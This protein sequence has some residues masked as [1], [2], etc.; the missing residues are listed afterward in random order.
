MPYHPE[1]RL[2]FSEPDDQKLAE[3]LRR[4]AIALSPFEA[5]RLVTL[6]GREPTLA[7]ATLFAI[8]WSEHCSYKSSRALLKKYLP[9]EGPT[10][11]QGPAEDA[12]IL[13]FGVWEGI[14]YGLVIAHESHNHPSQVMPYEGAATGI[15]GIVR[16]V[17]CMGGD[18]LAVL[19]PLR[20]G[21]PNG[22]NAN[23]TREIISGVVAGIAGYGN[24]LGVPNLGGDVVFADCYDDNC[25]VN[26]GAIGIVRADRI[27]PS[28]VPPEAKDVQYV[29]VL[30]GKATDAS[31]FGG[32]AFASGVLDEEDE[33]TNKGAVQIPDPFLKRLLTVSILT[34][35][36]RCFAK[37]IK[38][39]FKD[40]GAGG[41][42]CASSEMAASGGF[43]V[44]VDLGAVPTSVAGL[45]PQ[46]IAC[47]ETQERYLFYVPEAFAQEFCVIFN[48][49][50]RIPAITPGAG[51]TVVGR[52]LTEQT[53]RAK[54]DDTTYIECPVKAITEGIRYD[55]EAKPRPQPAP[56]PDFPQP[57]DLG[58]V[59]AK[60]LALP[61][62]SS[63]E[64]LFRHYDTEVK[65]R[66]VI[67]PGEA[68]AG[69]FLPVPGCPRAVALS[70]DGNPFYGRIDPYTGGA[71]A[72]EECCRNL[73][74]V[75]ALPIGITDCLN[76]GNPEDPESFWELSEGVRGIGEACNGIG[77]LSDPTHPLPV[78]SG[79]VSLYNFSATGAS[80][81]PSPIIVGV[82]II[83]DVRYAITSQLKRAGGHLFLVGERRKELGGSEYLRMMTGE[84]GSSVPRFN[85]TEARCN[86]TGVMLAIQQG[87]VHACHDISN[88][89]LAVTL[90]EM[91]LSLEGEDGLGAILHLDQIDS[92]LRDDYLLFGETGGFICEVTP[93]NVDPFQ[94]MLEFN[95][96]KFWLIGEVV[97]KPILRIFKHDKILVDKAISDLAKGW[98]EALEEIMR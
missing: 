13:D 83:P 23:R 76:Y 82:G 25:L 81:Y 84:L 62:L 8:M 71:T 46:V 47:A 66:T 6:L 74:A 72:V 48:Q 94:S 12:G 68:D 78:V 45:Q 57:A 55:R 2:P 30:V 36:D 49:E 91:C 90:A 44:E 51:A 85:A 28:K 73:V 3:L 92:D 11:I 86:L 43:G 95:G 56:D 77:L 37:G 18:V 61:N 14:R 33:Q 70:C 98:R 59:L 52:T 41:F 53:Y 9:T 64:Y 63:R 5:R 40:L 54:K 42:A 31:G 24:P 60:M 75:G 38:I 15:G 69:V 39:G 17:Y 16:D 19:D 65:G 89:G 29:A 27:I 7:E 97:A 20:F 35:I 80:I 22:K 32:A 26:V 34:A 4:E 58:E 79:N 88:G 67:R 21:N 87:M 96:A 93:E 10:V 50:F 1:D